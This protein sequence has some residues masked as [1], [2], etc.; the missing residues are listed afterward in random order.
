[1]PYRPFGWYRCGLEGRT[2]GDV[3]HGSLA[4]TCQVE[5][6]H[7]LDYRLHLG[8]FV[9]HRRDRVTDNLML[10]W[11]FLHVKIYN[12]SCKAPEQISFNLHAGAWRTLQF[13]KESAIMLPSVQQSISLRAS[14]ESQA[15]LRRRRTWRQRGMGHVPRSQYHMGCWSCLHAR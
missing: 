8:L 2:R 11:V 7:R 4:R 6:I 1:M 10:E 15:P 14:K 12:T 5:A 9:I 13:K 3:R